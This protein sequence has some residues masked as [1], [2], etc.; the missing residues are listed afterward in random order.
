MVLTLSLTVLY[1]L[2]TR[3]E[4]RYWFSITEVEKI[5]CVVRT[6]SLHKTEKFHL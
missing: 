3:A 5:F 6:E 4:L 1:G 2:F